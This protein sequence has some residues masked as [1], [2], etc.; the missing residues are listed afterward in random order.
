VSRVDGP[1]RLWCLMMMM[2]MIMIVGRYCDCFA[3]QRICVGCQ[4]V[5][6]YNRLDKP[7]RAKAIEEL[8]SRKTQGKAGKVRTH[9]PR[10]CL[11]PRHSDCGKRMSGEPI[12][13]NRPEIGSQRLC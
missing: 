7:E 12:C 8:F 10:G 13:H 2:M 11:I 4:C 1:L 5:D 3:A 6:C 9:H